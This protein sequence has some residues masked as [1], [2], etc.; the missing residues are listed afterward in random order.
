MINRMI[1]NNI[2]MIINR[3]TC[4]LRSETSPIALHTVSLYY[5]YG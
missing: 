2:I 3:H 4:V 5:V 1:R